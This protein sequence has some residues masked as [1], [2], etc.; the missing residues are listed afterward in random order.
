MY[1]GQRLCDPV[2]T[3]RSIAILMPWQDCRAK[4][5]KRRRRII[6]VRLNPEPGADWA[7]PN[8][9]YHLILVPRFNAP[10]A[11]LVTRATRQV[12]AILFCDIARPKQAQNQ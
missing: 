4:H 9:Q 6:P 5:Q 1:R 10:Q 11:K 12:L 2:Q 7:V 3:L 8:A